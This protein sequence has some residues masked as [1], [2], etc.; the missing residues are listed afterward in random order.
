MA[1]VRIIEPSQEN[2]YFPQVSSSANYIRLKCGL[3]ALPDHS[4][5]GT[6]MQNIYVI[7]RCYPYYITCS[8]LQVDCLHSAFLVKYL[9][10]WVNEFDNPT[11]E[12]PW[13]EVTPNLFGV[14][15]IV[16]P[17][18]LHFYLIDI[19]KIYDLAKKSL[20]S[21]QPKMRSYRLYH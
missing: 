12:T 19:K 7:L 6:A 4:E 11:D 10:D 2:K 8:C 18:G 13:W 3:Y 5:S 21:H 17:L 1:T 15:I 16:R 20:T 9:P 14:Y